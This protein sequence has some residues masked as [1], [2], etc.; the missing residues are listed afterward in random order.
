MC[1]CTDAKGESVG[2]FTQH[3]NG[4]M[5]CRLDTIHGQSADDLQVLATF[6]SLIV[7]RPFAEFQWP[8]FS[9]FHRFPSFGARNAHGIVDATN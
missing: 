4:S 2:L 9:S 5:G 6:P 1:G 8:C 7:L 3:L